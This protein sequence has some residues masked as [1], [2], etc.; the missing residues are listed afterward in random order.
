[1]SDIAEAIQKLTPEQKKFFY[2]NLKEG[3]A[4][5]TEKVWRKN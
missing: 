5:I 3:I 1:M 4:E 2:K